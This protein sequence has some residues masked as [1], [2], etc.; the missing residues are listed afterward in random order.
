MWHS[1]SNNLTANA[2]VSAQL[3][4]CKVNYIKN[5]AHVFRPP[6]SCKLG[7][8]KTDYFLS[9]VITTDKT[10]TA[11]LQKEDTQNCRK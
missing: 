7:K 11:K 5:G 8:K 6:S 10:V 9:S 2:D 3:V 4:V 1:S